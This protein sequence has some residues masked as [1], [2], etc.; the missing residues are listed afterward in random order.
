MGEQL[1]S[2]LPPHLP[3]LAAKV[4]P[5]AK[6]KEEGHEGQNEKNFHVRP[7]QPTTTCRVEQASHL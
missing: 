1:E 7:L 5:H 2:S 3:L 4:P 6:H